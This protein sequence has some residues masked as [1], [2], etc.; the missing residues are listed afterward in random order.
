M[1]AKFKF[2]QGWGSTLA[3]T[4]MTSADFALLH[5]KGEEEKEGSSVRI[6]HTWHVKHH[7]I[8]SK[9]SSEW[10]QFV[11]LSFQYSAVTEHALLSYK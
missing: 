2:E 9:L 7:K 1:T 4:H 10:E 6:S 11:R 5:W 8:A 3:E